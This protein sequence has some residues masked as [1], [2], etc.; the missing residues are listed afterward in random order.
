MLGPFLQE[1]GLDPLKLPDI[2]EGFEVKPIIVTYSAWFKLTEGQFTGIT[3]VSRSG[4]QI[5][6]YIGKTLRVRVQLDFSD[7]KLSYNYLIKVMNLGPTGQILGSLNNFI[8]IADVLIDFNNDE[9][10]LQ[11]F[12]ISNVGRLRVRLSGNIL[13]DW[14]LNPFISVFMRIFDNVIM[15][16]VELTIRN[17]AQ[18]EETTIAKVGKDN[19]SSLTGY[20]NDSNK[21]I[22]IVLVF[23]DDSK[24]EKK[25]MRLNFLM[26]AL[27]VG[28]E[29]EVESGKMAE[30]RNLVFVKLHAPDEIIEQYGLYFNEKRF[31]KDSHLEFINPIFNI[32]GTKHERELLKIVRPQRYELSSIIAIG[33]RSVINVL[34]A[35]LAILWFSLVMWHY[36]RWKRL[37]ETD[38]SRKVYKDHEYTYMAEMAF[39]HAILT[40]L[41]KQSEETTIAKVGKDNFSSLTGYLNDSNKRIDI[42]LVFK[43]DGKDEKKQM[44]LNFLMNALQVGLE[45]EVESGKMA[46]HRNLVF[47]K[48]HAPDEII[49]QYGLYFNEKRFFKD[50]HLEFINPIFNIFGTKHEREL[51]KIVRTHYPGPDNYSTLERSTIVYKLL[52]EL[53][54]GDN[55]NHYGINKSAKFICDNIKDKNICTECRNETLCPLLSGSAYCRR[56]QFRQIIDKKLTLNHGI[57]VVIWGKL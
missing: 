8:A 56:A 49:E 13:F 21:R 9:I 47:V 39:V 28:L 41:V 48:L 11:Q 3:N 10:H 45:A 35:A 50:S 46:E 17:V 4:D 54:F 36:P 2:E 25:Q 22:D 43:D 19:F 14:L 7:I 20:L 29:A 31:F 6:S 24:D 33:I 12:S 55:M 30:H 51:L 15:K 27:Q 38:N 5:V 23:K 42:V 37:Q 40:I 26:N 34:T 16:F 57:C 53:P 52:L 18:S 44:R 32:F 1:N